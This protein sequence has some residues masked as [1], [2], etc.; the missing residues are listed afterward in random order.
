MQWHKDRFYDLVF[1]PAKHSLRFEVVLPKV[2][3]PMYEAFKKFI[4][5][6]QSEETI[7]HRRIERKKVRISSSLKK[8]DISLL[9]I[10]KDRDYE[11]ATEKIIHLMHEIFLI[12]LRDGL[13]YE[14]MIET[15]DIDRDQLAG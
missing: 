10:A 4:A 15:F 11:Y 8:G 1:D 3:R 6:R 14:Y 2:P 9:F 13:Y 7:A 5:E 12:F